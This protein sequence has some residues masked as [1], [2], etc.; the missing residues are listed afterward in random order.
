MGKGAPGTSVD[1]VTARALRV[2]LDRGRTRDA[3]IAAVLPACHGSRRAAAGAL[4]RLERAFRAQPDEVLARAVDALR[5]AVELL[6]EP[7]STPRSQ[8]HLVAPPA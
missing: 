1:V 7:A 5:S 2:A 8:L 4:D 6:P 3:A